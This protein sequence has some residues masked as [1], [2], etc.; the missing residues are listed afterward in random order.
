M[1]TT[2]QTSDH[3]PTADHRLWKDRINHNGLRLVSDRSCPRLL[4]GKRCKQDDC[5]CQSWLNNHGNRYERTNTGR[6]LIMWEPYSADD[7]RLA[8]VLTAATADGIDV[9]L[10]GVSPWNPGYTMAITFT[11]A[12][13]EPG[14]TTA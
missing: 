9:D 12:A 2:T 4:V 14:G 5:W 1:S 10:S 11:A 6:D 3:P 13:P 7:R 8:E